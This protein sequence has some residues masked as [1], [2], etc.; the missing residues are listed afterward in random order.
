MEAP[1]KLCL[2]CRHCQF[3]QGWGGT[4]VTP[5]DPA[6]VNCYK[7][8]DDTAPFD[9]VPF[10]EWCKLAETCHHYAPDTK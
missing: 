3:D 8:P 10:L 4:D 1:V 2:F 6:E 9:R 5:G 7:R